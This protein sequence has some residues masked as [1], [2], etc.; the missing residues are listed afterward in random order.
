[1]SDACRLEAF[2][3]DVQLQ[4]DDGSKVTGN[5]HRLSEVNDY[6][7]TM[8]DG[9][10]VEKDQK[11]VAFRSARGKPLSVVIHFLHGCDFQTC[12]FMSS[13][14][15]VNVQ[16]DVLGLCDLMLLPSLQREVEVRV[17]QNLKLESACDV[18]GRALEL[19]MTGFRKAA[20]W[21]VLTEKMDS[22]R[23]C[24][25]LFE[26]VSGKYGG[27]VLDDVTSLVRQNVYVNDSPSTT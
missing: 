19:G 13:E 2:T 20:L 25:C 11:V 15:S 14:L 9:H 26:L 10:F 7:R 12:A 18:Y 21:F 3:M 24:E 1:M 5:R 27:Q 17:R 8:L 22:K 4:A 23:Q 16:L 6:F